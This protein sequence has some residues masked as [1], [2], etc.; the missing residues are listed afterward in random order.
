MAIDFSKIMLGAQNN[1]LEPRDIFMS[2]PSKEKKY[3][4]PRDVQSDVWKKW[5][6]QR[7]NKNNII[8]MNT[9]SGKTTVGLLILKSCLNEGVGPAVY[10][11]PDGYLVDQV[12]KE[13]QSLG[14]ET[15]T[16]EKDIKFIR[17][18]SI[19]II[20]IHKLINGKSVFGMRSSNNVKIGSIIIDDA[21]AC[22]S[23]IKNQYTLSIPNNSIMY[24]E[25][26]KLFSEPLKN[27][28]ANKFIE[29]CNKD[30]RDLFML[31]PYWEW[32]Q[33]QSDVY[34]IISQN[35]DDGDSLSFSLP[36]LKE[37][38]QFCDC[39]ISSTRIEI[40]I[41]S[42]PI[43]NITSF[44]QAERRIFMT[45]TLADDSVLSSELGLYPED[46]SNII[47]PDKAND[48]G[49]RLIIMPQVRN[50]KI[51]DAEIKAKIH[52]YAQDNN[53]VVLV[54]SKK[55]AEFWSDISNIEL[56]IDNMKDGVHQ[57]K[58]GHVGLAVLINKYDG[59]DL[60]DDAC[61][62]LV[63]DGL[64]PMDS[65]YDQFERNANPNSSRLKCEQIQKLEQGMGRGV[66]S[67]SDSCA[68]ILMGKDV[69]EIIYGNN[70]VNY[71]SK[72]TRMQLDISEQLCDQ[73]DT[74]DV[75]SVMSICNYSLNKDKNWIALSK[76]AL[77]SVE[78]ETQPNFN[79]YQVA[80]RKAFDSAERFQY[81]TAIS[82]ID[83]EINKTNNKELKGLLFQ[84]KAELQNFNDVELS[85]ETLLI[86]NSFNRMLL[87]PINGIVPEK[88]SA[89]IS[90]QGRS[91]SDYIKNNDMTPN[92]FHIKVDSVLNDLCFHSIS[93][94]RF[95]AAFKE[96]GLILGL[97]STRP[98][99]EFGN[100]PDNLWELDNQQ[101]IVI[102]CKNEAT[103][104]LISK[105]D[106]N[107]LNGSINWLD[108]HY[109]GHQDCFP[110]MVH[111]SSVFS[112]D[113]SPESRIRIIDE[114]LLEKLKDAVRMFANSITNKF[115][116]NDVMSITASLK[117]YKLI[118]SM[119][120]DNYTKKPKI[121][122]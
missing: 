39:V 76:S 99:E 122:G 18:Q 53:V 10:V 73:L 40:S 42:I 121:K 70:G 25:I 88:Y 98:E 120:V 101:F 50:L 45:A 87:N 67:N 46:V 110:I 12:C 28:C 33:H 16:D 115:S 80:I 77:S 95:E 64:P 6:E 44:A 93:S 68:V 14:L 107:Q 38:F 48:I 21:H 41:K 62:I 20:N 85:Q 66:R 118:G 52:D 75:D 65:L 29:L 37:Y 69:G 102:E 59:V 23:T 1:D 72:A 82:Y 47:S 30:S 91:I 8:K 26:L 19:L 100:G 56:T 55:K 58:N 36:L 24:E 78:Y 109:H 49:D 79:S 94:Q 112:H 86:A 84:Y 43:S 11:V 4:Y 31:V 90:D 3:E 60:P 106:C 7:Q 108:H 89:K 27:Q 92:G 34:E 116:F 61:K 103:T 83:V 35:I 114:I 13:A 32:Q 96:L 71:F 17:N 97:G 105:K 81:D 117:T 51:T 15:S 9:G 113:C 2:L 22:L 54:P 111:H 63:I 57:L 74:L 119:I 104:E 5:F